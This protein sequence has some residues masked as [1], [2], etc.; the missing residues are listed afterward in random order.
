MSTSRAYVSKTGIF[1]EITR[2]PPMHQ[3]AA[4]ESDFV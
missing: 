2:K 4:L 3:V 1:G